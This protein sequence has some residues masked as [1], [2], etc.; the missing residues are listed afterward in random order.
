L[1]LATAAPNAP[2]GRS[3]K[4][5]YPADSTVSSFGT[6]GALQVPSGKGKEMF[7]FDRLIRRDMLIREVKQ[8]HPVTKEV[9]E[10]IGFRS[11]C[12]DCDIETVARKNGLD[13]LDVLDR[14]N[15]AAFA[16]GTDIQ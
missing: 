9:F 14:L 3:A 8:Q 6:S 10:E 2:P 15:R 13:L 11:A 5:G 7:R 12:D 1:R 16:P 4:R